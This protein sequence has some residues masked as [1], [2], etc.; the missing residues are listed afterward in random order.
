M[1]KQC[2]QWKWNEQVNTESDTRMF[3]LVYIF[4]IILE[5]EIPILYPIYLAIRQG[6]PLC[7]LT[8]EKGGV[9]DDN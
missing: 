6:F 8:L 5:G 9:F 3:V 7:R 2:Q 1:S 4:G